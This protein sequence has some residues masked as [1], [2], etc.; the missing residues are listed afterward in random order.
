MKSLAVFPLAALLLTHCG[1]K[2]D[3]ESSRSVNDDIKSTIPDVGTIIIDLPSAVAPGGG[4]IQLADASENIKTLFLVPVSFT[5]VAG[6]MTTL[7][8]SIIDHI[9]GKPVCTDSDT[10]NDE[11]DCNAYRGIVTG[12]VSE[13]PTVFEVPSSDSDA[14]SHVKY[15][16]NPA[17]SDYDVGIELYWPNGKG[18]YVSALQMQLSKTGEK[19]GKG[20]LTFFP[21]YDGAGSAPDVIVT[22]FEATEDKKTMALQIYFEASTQLASLGLSVTDSNGLISG[23]GSAIRPAQ[24]TASGNFAPFQTKDEFAYVFT[25]AADAARNIAVEK[26]AAVQAAHYADEANFFTSYGVDGLLKTFTLDLLR[27]DTSNFNC[28]TSGKYISTDLPVNIC[29]SNTAVT[30]AAVLTGLATFCSNNPTNDTICPVAGQT[31]RWANP[32]Y[33]NAEGYVGNESYQKPGD[34]AYGLLVEAMN[35]VTVYTPTALKAQT[36]PELPAAVEAVE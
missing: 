14:P 8:K 22:K 34:T 23:S 29:Q 4:N 13:T 12:Q 2:T 35:A 9:F 26:M 19:Q 33:L 21:N 15:W 10:S 17:G 30:D 7:T 6:Q 11:A 36:M 1:K 18:S 25:L 3:D 32:I 28:T 16:A 20:E 24:A 5:G 31:S 27:K